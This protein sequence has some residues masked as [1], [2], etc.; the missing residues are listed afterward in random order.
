MLTYLD[1]K[2]T[3]SA[4]IIFYIFGGVHTAFVLQVYGL[5]EFRPVNITGLK[6]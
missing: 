6:V 4:K 1:K 5:G 3:E 2:Y